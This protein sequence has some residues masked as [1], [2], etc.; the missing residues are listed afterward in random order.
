MGYMDKEGGYRR[1]LGNGSR[2]I[3]KGRMGYKKGYR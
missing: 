2:G 3:R 1:V